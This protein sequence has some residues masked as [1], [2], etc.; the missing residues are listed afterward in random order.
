[1]DAVNIDLDEMRARAARLAGVIGK[2]WCLGPTCFLPI[3]FCSLPFLKKDI[4]VLCVFCIFLYKRC[5]VLMYC[6][7]FVFV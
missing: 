2:L 4:F 3:G 7:L 1:M 5:L 6:D